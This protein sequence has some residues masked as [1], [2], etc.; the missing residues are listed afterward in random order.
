M[1]GKW[2]RQEPGGR[3]LPCTEVVWLLYL[4]HPLE[5]FHSALDEHLAAIGADL[6]AL[7]DRT[8]AAVFRGAFGERVGAGT[9]GFHLQ[10]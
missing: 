4:P 3:L 1:A 8:L 2:D 10:A 7:D 9:A 6:A 5:R